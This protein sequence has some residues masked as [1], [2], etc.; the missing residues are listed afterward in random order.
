MLAMYRLVNFEGWLKVVG[1]RLGE[2]LRVGDA[3]SA[4]E[5]EWRS[6]RMGPVPP[7][8]RRLGGQELLGLW[9]V[10]GELYE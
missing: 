3:L 10:G 9:N 5:S 7:V 1:L 8:Y 4:D 6:P 2:T